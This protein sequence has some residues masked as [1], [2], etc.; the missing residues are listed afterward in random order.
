[1]CRAKPYAVRPAS[2]QLLGFTEARMNHPRGIK[3]AD[4]VMAISR[5]T[6]VVVTSAMAPSST[7]A[8]LTLSTRIARTDSGML[9]RTRR[10]ITR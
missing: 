2:A 7:A 5:R 1:M 3:T 6:A 10:C 4:S 8:R 9:S